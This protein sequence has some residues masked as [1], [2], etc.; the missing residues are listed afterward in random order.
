MLEGHWDF[1]GSESIRA[2]DLHTSVAFGGYGVF[3]K[4]MED[5]AAGWHMS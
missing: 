4:D 2:W 1:E 3:G 5:G